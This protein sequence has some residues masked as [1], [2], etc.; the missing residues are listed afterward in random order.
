MD[1]YV[2]VYSWQR[3]C[4]IQSDVVGA[5]LEETLSS[6]GRTSLNKQGKTL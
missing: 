6:T 1:N 5:D 3:S 4:V 2:H